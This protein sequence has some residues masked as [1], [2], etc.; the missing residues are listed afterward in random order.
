M[1]FKL[2]ILRNSLLAALLI[3]SS[4]LLAQDDNEVPF[5]IVEQVPIYKGCNKK[6]S[7]IELKKC[8][9][10]GIAKHLVKNF[11]I[12]VAKDLGLPDGKVKINIVFKV[13]K[14][15]KIKDI[16]ATGPHQKLEEEAFRVINLIP[17]LTKPGYQKGKPVTVPYMLPLVFNIDNSLYKN[18]QKNKK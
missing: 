15:G 1:L 13:D 4:F 17:K 16:K 9:S 6:L 10:N 5:A 14:N 7:N 3:S 11:N 12:S 18:N 2:I 8:M